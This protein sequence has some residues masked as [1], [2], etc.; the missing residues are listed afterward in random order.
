MLQDFNMGK[1]DTLSIQ[2]YPIVAL[3][4]WLCEHD[5]MTKEDARNIFNKSSF[6]FDE[7]QKKTSY[8]W[9]PHS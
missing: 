7:F 6:P 3:L 5:K 9:E 1:G 2:H 8:I 4:D